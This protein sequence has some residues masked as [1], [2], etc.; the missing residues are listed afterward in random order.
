MFNIIYLLYYSK[1]VGGE[2]EKLFKKGRFTEKTDI[3]ALKKGL[4]EKK[5]PFL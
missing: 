5:A 1:G 4:L 3:K 2:S